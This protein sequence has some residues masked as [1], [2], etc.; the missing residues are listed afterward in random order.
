MSSDN[1]YTALGPAAIGFQTDGANIDVG[2]DVFGNNIG[3]VGRSDN[4]PGVKGESKVSGIHGEG[5][6]R[7]VYGV[8]NNPYDSNDTTGVLGEGYR[9]AVGVAG[10]CFSDKTPNDRTNFGAVAGVLGVSNGTNISDPNDPQS[11]L[12]AGVV[13]LSRKRVGHNASPV[14][15]LPMPSLRDRV[16]G[17]GVGVWGASGSG[18]GVYAQSESG[19]GAVFVSQHAAQVRLVPTVGAKTLPAAG[20]LGDIYVF[21]VIVNRRTMKPVPAVY[22]CV[23]QG[24]GTSG[25][26]AQWAS[27][28]LGAAVKGGI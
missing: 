13:G 26:E 10:L 7:G 9:N 8:G 21:S 18:T 3:A 1:Q 24:D 23:A 6:F 19:R 27:F 11:P 17:D 2:A 16:D 20:E 12:G 15:Y 4:G 22:L 5:G 28:Q 25:N 14:D